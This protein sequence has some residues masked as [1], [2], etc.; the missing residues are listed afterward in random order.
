MEFKTIGVQCNDGAF[1]QEKKGDFNEDYEK[2]YRIT[3][4]TLFYES[5]GC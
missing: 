4:C 2:V 5:D 1:F 3:Y